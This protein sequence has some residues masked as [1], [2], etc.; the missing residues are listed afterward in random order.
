MTAAQDRPANAATPV[1]R[2]LREWRAVRRISQLDLALD[3]DISTRHLS[4]IETGKAQPS[5]ALLD[6]L[7][8]TLGMP[9]RERNA[10]L[11]AA[12][13]APIYRESG[14]S[15]PELQLLARAVDSILA[16]QEPYPAFAVDRC[17]NVLAVNRG[18]TRLL[19]SIKPGGP[20]H[21]NILRQVFDPGDM[22][23]HIGNWDEVAGDL[24]RHLHEACARNPVDH[25][26]HALLDE[27]LAFPE[28]PSG[29]R[30]REARAPLPVI[31]T[32]FIGP[33]GP[34]SFF[35]T[36]TGFGTSWDITA[37]ETRIECMHPVDEAAR[38]YCRALA[39]R[40]W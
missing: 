37:E 34:L 1:G 19:G 3:S 40:D 6:Q 24:I 32:V 30:R 29:W 4:C 33:T 21:G 18:M 8:D 36:L 16:Q 17:W 15:A 9:L 31:T 11:L 13:Y 23:P 39:E 35:S 7:A 10:L 26:L 14:L 20:L 28:V 27:V 2:M 5:R 22:R 25:A 12:G 38:A